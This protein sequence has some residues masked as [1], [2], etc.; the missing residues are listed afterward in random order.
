MQRHRIQ[1]HLRRSR[2]YWNPLHESR[3][4]RKTLFITD[5]EYEC[6]KH[7]PVCCR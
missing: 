7:V 4:K 6:G 2:R 1:S 3:R 5:R